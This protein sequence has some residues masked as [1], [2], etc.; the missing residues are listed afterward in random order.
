MTRPRA[1]FGVGILLLAVGLGLLLLAFNRAPTAARSSLPVTTP[2]VSTLTIEPPPCPIS[3][4]WAV[5]I[6][7]PNYPADPSD[8]RW[9]C[10]GALTATPGYT[11]PPTATPIATATVTPTITVDQLLQSWSDDKNQQQQVLVKDAVDGFLFV[12]KMCCGSVLALLLLAII[13]VV[14]GRRVRRRY[15]FNAPGSGS[16]TWSQ[17]VPDDGT[18]G[19]TDAAGYRHPLT[20]RRQEGFLPVD[21]EI[22]L[23]FLRGWRAVLLILFARGSVKW[24]AFF[25][26][27]ALHVGDDQVQISERIWWESRD[28]VAGQL[29]TI[30][31][32]EIVNL[33]GPLES[34]LRCVLVKIRRNVAN[35]FIPLDTDACWWPVKPGSQDLPVKTV[36]DARGQITHWLRAA[37]AAKSGLEWGVDTAKKRKRE[38]EEPGPG[39]ARR[40]IQ[41]E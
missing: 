28:V 30:D 23:P 29:S 13:A 32:L 5:K 41:T 37:Q 34:W 4:G 39:N 11:P 10:T 17:V 26:Q 36:Q 6:D 40:S 35:D 19:L 38:R 8:W 2:V 1:V 3:A 14:A 33:W 18:Q 20:Y 7:G 27:G 24:R 9:D 21:E 15:G 31:D 12:V 25:L 16:S 22:R